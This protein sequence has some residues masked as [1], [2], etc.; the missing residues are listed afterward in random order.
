MVLFLSSY[1]CWT[2]PR[3]LLKVG[4]NANTGIRL[5]LTQIQKKILRFTLNALAQDLCFLFSEPGKT[6]LCPKQMTTSIFFFLDKYIYS[7]VCP[8][9]LP[10]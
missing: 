10:T 5:L 2:S 4:S 6:L 7:S 3:I 1:L 8:L 9:F